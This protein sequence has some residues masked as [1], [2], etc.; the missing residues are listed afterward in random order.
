MIQ[1]SDYW[2]HILKKL[3]PVCWSTTL[4]CHV[5]LSI[6]HNSKGR[7]TSKHASTDEQTCKWH[8]KKYWAFQKKKKNEMYPQQTGWYYA[9]SKNINVKN[10]KAVCRF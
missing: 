6:F 9:K 8:T 4:H 2:L 1:L 10:L 7:E 3:N 5:H